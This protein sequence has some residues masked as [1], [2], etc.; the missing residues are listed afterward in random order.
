M[1]VHVHV[2]LC[3]TR[4]RLSHDLNEQTGKC[5]TLGFSHLVW[6]GVSM[7]LSVNIISHCHLDLNLVSHTHKGYDLK[8]YINLVIN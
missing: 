4:T 2:H 3:T 8:T 7:I 6:K 1:S 5:E